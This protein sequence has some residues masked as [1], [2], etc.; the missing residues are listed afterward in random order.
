VRF[1]YDVNGLL[2]VEA[3]VLKTEETSTLVIEGNPGLMSEREIEQRLK[4]LQELKIHP[5]D[6]LENRTLMA[7]GERLYEQFKGDQ[8][9]WLGVQLLRFEKLLASQDRH[10]IA[11]G[12]RD[13][14]ALLDRVERDSYIDGGPQ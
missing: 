6:R 12:R 1:T 7:R 3:T 2:Q 14:A 8:R 10:A 5:R 9:E 4:A 13:L 11:A